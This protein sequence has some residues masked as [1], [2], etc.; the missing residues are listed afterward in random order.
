MLIPIL[1]TF[2]LAIVLVVQAILALI[3]LQV[4]KI[5][6]GFQPLKTEGTTLLESDDEDAK[7]ESP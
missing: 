6:H 1:F 4:K 2:H 5:Q 3:I 7:V